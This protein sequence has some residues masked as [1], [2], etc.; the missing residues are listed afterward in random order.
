MRIARVFPLLLLCVLAAC[1][2]PKPPSDPYAI[3]VSPASSAAP[4][5]TVVPG[6][7]PDAP[8]AAAPVQPPPG[9]ACGKIPAT[10]GNVPYRDPRAGSVKPV[11]GQMTEQAA[12]AKRL[13]DGEKWSE[14]EVA[15]K[16]VADGETGDDEGNKQLADY[17]RAI[18]LFRLKR[19]DE[20][21]ARFRT[22]SRNPGHLK[23]FETLL[24]IVKLARDEPKVVRLEDAALYTPEEIA[25]FDNS[26]Q[27]D[28]FGAAAYLVGHER[29][30]EGN[31]SEA[32]KL[33]EIA[34]RVGPWSNEAERCLARIAQTM[35]GGKR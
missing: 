2:D 19:F 34:K 3:H 16:R 31:L 12:Q 25:R 6:P 14:A 5:L 30:D 10:R 7:T 26:N 28:T 23:F 8:V 18:V 20:S 27:R 29:Y 33:F 24:W 32:Q 15:L 13:F 9:D 22:F 35:P 17:H 4:A 11:A 1:G 21:A